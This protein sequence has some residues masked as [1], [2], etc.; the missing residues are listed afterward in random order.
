MKIHLFHT[1]TQAV[2]AGEIELTLN[3]PVSSEELWDL[4]ILSHPMLKS[5]RPYTRMACNHHYVIESE[6][7]HPDDEIALIPPVSGG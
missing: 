6:L 2:G 1:L 4:L 5:F 3:A 7:I